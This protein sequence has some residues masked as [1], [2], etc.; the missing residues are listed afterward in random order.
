MRLCAFVHLTAVASTLL[1]AGCGADGTDDFMTTS[2]VMEEAAARRSAVIGRP[3][4]DFTLPDQDGRPVMLSELR[5]KGVELYF[6]PKDDTPGCACQATEFTQ[7]LHDFGDMD[8]EVLGVSMDSPESHRHFREK[9]LLRLTLLSDVNHKVMQSY[10]AWVR[11]AL[12]GELFGRVIR[13]TYLIG[14]DGVI[15]YHWPEVIPTGHAERLRRKLA[16][17]QAAAR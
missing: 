7:L 15:R 4:P 16:E 11:S 2:N 3:S 8:A 12:G 17:L 9:Y 10:G 6:Y 14:P 1:L 13:S 5:P